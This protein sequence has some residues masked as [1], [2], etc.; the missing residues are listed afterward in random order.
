MS[1]AGDRTQA[2][3]TFEQ[4]LQDEFWY[5]TPDILAA[6]PPGQQALVQEAYQDYLA[7]EDWVLSYNPDPDGGY[8]LIT[9]WNSAESQTH[10]VR[11]S[12][13]LLEEMLRALDA[14]PAGP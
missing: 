10:T 4:F 8:V 2:M 13:R 11:V 1:E 7:G 3:K 12:G 9:S 6:R 14:G 5:L